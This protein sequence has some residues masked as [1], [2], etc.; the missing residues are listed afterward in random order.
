MSLDDELKSW[1]SSKTIWGGI[2]SGVSVVATALFKLEFPV[3]FTTE[4][5]TLLAG[6]FGSGLAIYGRIKA[7]KKIK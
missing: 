4:M 5:A 7:V 6:I 1:L 2:I 3:D